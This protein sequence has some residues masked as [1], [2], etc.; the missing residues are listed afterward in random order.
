MSGEGLSP[1]KADGIIIGK[2]LAASLDVG[3]GDTVVLLAN[4]G[5]GGLGA[6]EATILGTFQTS[7][8]AYD[9]VSIRVPIEMARRLLRVEGAHKWVILLNETEQTEAALAG[10]RREFAA[11]GNLEFIPWSDLADF[12]NKSKQLFAA[13]LNVIWLV[14]ATI[15]IVSISNT[16][17]M[18]VM[19]RT[20]EIGTLMALGLKRRKILTLFISEGFMLGCVGGPSAR[21]SR[22]RDRGRRFRHRHSLPCA[23]HGFSGARRD[24][25]DLRWPRAAPCSVCWRRSLPASTRRARP[26]TWSSS[27]LCGTPLIAMFKLALRNLF[28]QKTRTLITLVTIVCGVAGLILAGGFV[29]DVYVQLRDATIK[30]RFGYISSIARAIPY[31]GS[32]NPIST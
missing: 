32:V 17:I 23:G 4:S 5:S 14:I 11:H 7:N 19:E 13:Q 31:S 9:D 10:L 26:R 20:G 29:E 3:P 22:H 24:H 28:R 30:S 27:T 2:G 8:K 16:L 6:A 25:G 1:S 21:C 15:I 18:N 12:Y